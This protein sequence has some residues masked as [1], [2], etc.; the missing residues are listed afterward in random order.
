MVHCPRAVRVVSDGGAV[1]G[2]ENFEG[3]EVD[4]A[5]ADGEVPFFVAD[6]AVAPS[7]V[8]GAE[9]RGEFDG[10]G[11]GAAVAGAVVGGGGGGGGGGHF[12]GW[13]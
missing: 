5:R 7:E 1:G 6:G 3:A 8:P 11:D 10:V 9:G 4:I 12:G 13:G 2:G